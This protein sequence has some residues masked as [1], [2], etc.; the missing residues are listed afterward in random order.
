[1]MRYHE[2]TNGENRTVTATYCEHETTVAYETTHLNDERGWV[3]TSV[4]A[5]VECG[6][7]LATVRVDPAR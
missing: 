1:M 5:C 3:R 6:E 7:E 4:V 2:R